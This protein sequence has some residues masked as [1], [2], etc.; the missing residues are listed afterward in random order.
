LAWNFSP[1]KISG[2][3]VMGILPHLPVGNFFH[4]KPL[5]NHFVNGFLCA[6]I[7]PRRMELLAE[8]SFYPRIWAL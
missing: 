7:T 4:R 8:E 1:T 6:K 5:W 3:P 2:V